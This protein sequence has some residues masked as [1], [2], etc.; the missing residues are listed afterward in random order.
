MMFVLSQPAVAKVTY[1]PLAA[2]GEPMGSPSDL[3]SE[4]TYPAGVNEVELDPS[5]L[6]SGDFE[7]V[8]EAR[9]VADATI[10]DRAPT[11]TSMRYRLA[12]TLPVGQT[13]I[14]GVNLR[15]GILTYQTPRLNVPGRGSPLDFVVSYSSA[16][17]GQM[18]GLA[19]FTFPSSC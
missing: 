2:A 8:V 14:N 11:R 10:T 17:A 3:T 4:Q 19:K 15:N 5:R 16:A 12:N 13:L 1:Q 6:G 9:A 18:V 7:L